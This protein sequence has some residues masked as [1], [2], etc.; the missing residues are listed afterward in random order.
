MRR[1]DNPAAGVG[2]I[3]GDEAAAGVGASRPIS[4][5]PGSVP[6][7][8]KHVATPPALPG[9]RVPMRPSE[10]RELLARLSCFQDHAPISHCLVTSPNHASL[11]QGSD[12]LR[13]GRRD[14]QRGRMGRARSIPLA[15]DRRS[16]L[17]Q[18]RNHGH[19][20]HR[21]VQGARGWVRTHCNSQE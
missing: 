7:A 4:P 1:V 13:P 18:A 3:S 14:T 2:V 11:A 6:L 17:M 20:V 10:P 19:P 12:L 15:P 9:P 16:K 5:R 21:A 8:S